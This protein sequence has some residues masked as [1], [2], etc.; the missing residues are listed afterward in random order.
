MS[1]ILIVDDLATEIQVMKGVIAGL[2]HEAMA[3]NDGEAGFQAAKQ[4]KPDLILMDVVMPKMDG[5][6][7]CR[8]L[9]KDPE[10]SGI[11]VIMV[12]SK[13]NDTDRSWGL[14]QGAVDYIGKPFSP[15]DLSRAI[16][17]HVKGI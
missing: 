13:N 14:K 11:P 12:T 2:G 5:Y 3:V 10:T 15:D 6:Q 8:K 4:Y 16:R 17:T 1:K 7:T 9:K